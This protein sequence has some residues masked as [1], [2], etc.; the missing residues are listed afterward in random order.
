MN[1]FKS[2][3]VGAAA[4]FMVHGQCGENVGEYV[5]VGHEEMSADLL[6]LLWL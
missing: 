3:F 4:D 2:F 1:V 6:I 5:V